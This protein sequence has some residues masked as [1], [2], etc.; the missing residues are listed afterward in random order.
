MMRTTL[1]IAVALAYSG[2]MVFVG[3]RLPR[4]ASLMAYSTAL[5]ILL[6]VP[7]FPESTVQ[8][9]D[10]VLGVVG[11]GRLLV[12]LAFMTALSSLFLTVVLATQ[13]WAWRH[14]LMV[15]GVVG[16]MGLFVVC[17]RTVH[18]LG[19][20]DMAA[21]FYGH[22]ASPPTPVLWM[23][24]VR[25]SGIVYI[26][27]WG[28]AEFHHFLRR[29]RRTYESSMVRVALLLYSA[30][31]L[32]GTLT[33]V[34][35]VGRHRSL[36]MAVVQQ[37]RIAFTTWVIAGTAVVL[38]GQIWLRPLWRQRR[39][40]LARYVAPELAQLRHDLLNLTAAQ[41][42]LHLDIHHVA[43]TN[44][45]IVDDVVAR[46]RAA[47]I[48]PA[49][50]AMARMATSLLTFHRDNLLQDPSYGLVTSWE[51]LTEEAATEMDQAMARTAW[52]QALRDGYITQQVY[53][54]MFLVLDSRTYRE[55]LLIDERPRVEGWHQQLAD[56]IAT[57]LHAHGHA[58]PRYGQVALQT[59]QGHRLAW[60]RARRTATGRAARAGQSLH[61]REDE[62]H[63]GEGTPTT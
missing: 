23:N 58:T 33:I 41:A 39:Q 14:Q 5:A 27:T 46:C 54:L 50:V 18:T 40:L 34:E 57:V 30:T 11:A 35:S 62:R 16:L 48:R 43:Y 49:R 4:P 60:L 29:G 28:L 8:H 42:E 1:L 7:L 59:T 44:R 52:E 17:W 22:G 31:G 45:A 61:G 36:D 15:S 19:L 51:D 26:A 12:H 38:V 37:G 9:V 13:P 10:R 21:V 3:R 24:V 25:G 6:A 55:I 20:P 2:A 63:R 53:I 32:I 56:L 47:G